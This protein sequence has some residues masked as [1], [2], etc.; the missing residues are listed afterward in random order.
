MITNAFDIDCI[1]GYHFFNQVWQ[2]TIGEIL[3]GAHEGNF[4]GERQMFA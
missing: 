3:I 4:T 1:R 2:P